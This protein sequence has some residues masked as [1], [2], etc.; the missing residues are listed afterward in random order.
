MTE[1]EIK[2]ILWTC[3][4]QHPDEPIDEHGL[5]CDNLEVIEFTAK[6]EEALALKYARIERGLCIEFVESLNPEV[7][8]KLREKRGDM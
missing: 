2:D 6:V 3:K 1:Q 4:S 5:Y 7:A 8:T